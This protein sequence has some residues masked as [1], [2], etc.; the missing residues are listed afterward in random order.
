MYLV[1][2]V[3]LVYLDNSGV[4]NSW[5][6]AQITHLGKNLVVTDPSPPQQ[7]HSGCQPAGQWECQA[8]VRVEWAGVSS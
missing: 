7:D 3:V 5:Y 2:V 4:R 1:W 6:L 8:L